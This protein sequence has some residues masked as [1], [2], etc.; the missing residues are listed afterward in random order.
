MLL[1]L[2]LPVLEVELAPLIAL[3]SALEVLP[4]LEMLLMKASSKGFWRHRT[5][6]KAHVPTVD[7]MRALP[8]ARVGFLTA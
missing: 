3:A 2:E 7:R 4:R 6:G 8:T 1:P 5:A